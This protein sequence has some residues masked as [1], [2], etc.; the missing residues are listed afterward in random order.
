MVDLVIERG[1]H[2]SAWQA[3]GTEKH[4]IGPTIGSTNKSVYNEQ[5]GTV[6]RA[7][8]AFSHYY[9]CRTLLWNKWFFVSPDTV[10]S[11]TQSAVYHD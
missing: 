9:L 5:R 3:G 1:D 4:A 2:G 7:V 10:S 11:L 6:L 8:P